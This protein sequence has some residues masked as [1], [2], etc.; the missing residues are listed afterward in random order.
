MSHLHK[1]AV[2]LAA[3][4]YQA[5]R[6][7][8]TRGRFTLPQG[9]RLRARLGGDDSPTGASSSNRTIR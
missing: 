5:V 1:E 3:V 8:K 7:Y 2:F 6:Q 4:V 9:F